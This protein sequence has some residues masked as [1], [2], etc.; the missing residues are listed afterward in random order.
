MCVI[1]LLTRT[2]Y[3]HTLALAL[4]EPQSWYKAT[5]AVGQCDI[6]T[7]YNVVLVARVQGGTL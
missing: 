5:L 3:F 1:Y 4:C 6:V 2:I 7:L